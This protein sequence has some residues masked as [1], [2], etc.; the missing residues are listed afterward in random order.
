MTDHPINYQGEAQLY[1]WSDSS[2]GRKVTFLLPDEGN[3]HPFKPFKP[4]I[5]YG[6]CFAICTKP[7]DYDNP[8]EPKP[9][10]EVKSVAGYAKAPP[11]ESQICAML[12]DDPVFQEWLVDQYPPNRL[13]IVG[14][15]WAVSVVKH[16]CGMKSRRE[17]DSD[18]EGEP[19]KRW[20]ALR[21]QYETD[22]GKRAQER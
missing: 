6:Q 18:P 11:T 21:S 3:E 1:S 14:S 5:K 20:Q 22:T 13:D 9:G 7:I 19:S 12:C 4:G 17:L 15:A 16:H 8:Q 2:A 10:E